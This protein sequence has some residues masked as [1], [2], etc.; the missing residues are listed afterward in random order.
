MR[1][2]DDIVDHGLKKVKEK[3]TC[4]WKHVKKSASVIQIKRWWYHMV[5][6]VNAE[7]GFNKIFHLFLI[8]EVPKN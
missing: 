3:K 6:L 1:E 4:F 5:I 2:F 7:K 8:F